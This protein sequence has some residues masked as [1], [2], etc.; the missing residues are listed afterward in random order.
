MGALENAARR[1]SEALWRHDVLDTD[2]TR[3]SLAFA[4]DRLAKECEAAYPMPENM[5]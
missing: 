3:E 5:E 2:E 4:L 1:Y